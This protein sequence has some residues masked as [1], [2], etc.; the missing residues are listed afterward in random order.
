MFNVQTNKFIFPSAKKRIKVLTSPS[1]LQSFSLSNHQP[2]SVLQTNYHTVLQTYQP[3]NLQT[4]Q[5][6]LQNLQSI[7]LYCKTYSPSDFIAK[8]TVH[9]TL[10]QN[11]QSIRLNCKTYS[12]SDFIAKLTVLQTINPSDL[13]SI[14]LT[15]FPTT[16]RLADPTNKWSLQLIESISKD[17]QIIKH[18]T[19]RALTI[20][21]W[22]V[23]T[24][25]R[26]P[27]FISI[28]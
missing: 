22:S 24:I 2:D 1:D 4:L 28:D 14:S 17:H 3:T 27:C 10:L 25:T 6:L 13:Q 23:F 11:L 19:R 21:H 12:P 16:N 15:V 7:R 9:Q 26:F 20:T 18:L 5:I 8:L